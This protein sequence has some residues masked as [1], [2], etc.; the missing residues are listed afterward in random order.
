MG[1]RETSGTGQETD[2]KWRG[3]GRREHR[4]M[5]REEGR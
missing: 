3:S 4:G 5:R 1:K 2:G